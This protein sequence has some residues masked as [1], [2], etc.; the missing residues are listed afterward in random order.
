MSNVKVRSFQASDEEAIRALAAA[1]YRYQF[2]SASGYEMHHP[3]ILQHYSGIHEIHKNKGC[4]LCA[5][6]KDKIAGFVCLQGPIKPGK[7]QGKE[8]YVFMSDLYV[9]E[10]SRNQG[11]GSVL[12]QASEAWAKG[13]GCSK[14]ALK[15]MAENDGAVRFYERN[16]YQ[17]RFVVM[18]KTLG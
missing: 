6:V 1:L 9:E 3:E 5:I 17:S 14:M 10:T 7:E 8:H 16:Q 15:V 13:K 18:D 12:M 2:P 11:V 4:V